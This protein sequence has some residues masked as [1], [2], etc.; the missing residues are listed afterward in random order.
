MTQAQLQEEV[1]SYFAPRRLDGKGAL[2]AAEVEPDLTERLGSDGRA[3]G[4]SGAVF[5][6]SDIAAP[7]REPI[8]SPRPMRPSP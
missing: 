3:G 1:S 7:A 6:G 4:F 5:G 8:N 2:P